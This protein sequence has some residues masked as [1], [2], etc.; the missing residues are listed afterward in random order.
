MQSE[1]I[2]IHR[3][4]FIKSDAEQNIYNR[5]RD[6]E[7]LDT[8]FANLDYELDESEY[9]YDHWAVAVAN[10]MCRETGLSFGV[11]IANPNGKYKNRSSILYADKS[12]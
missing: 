4:S 3:T 2:N 6:G 9:A 1:H 7:G 8:V 11:H 12:P 10:V 5:I